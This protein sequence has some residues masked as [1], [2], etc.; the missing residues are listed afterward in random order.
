MQYQLDIYSVLNEII[1][2]DSRELD[3]DCFRE[4]DCERLSEGEQEIFKLLK[5]IASL[6][7]KYKEGE[8]VFSPAIEIYGKGRSFGLQDMT[9]DDYVILE[10]IEVSRLPVLLQAR[11]A[12]ILWTERKDYKIVPVAIK[13]YHE[14]YNI[15][16]DLENWP[17]CLR[18]IKRSITL[19]AKTGAKK[20]YDKY[21]K[22]VFD[23]VIE[24]N[25]EDKYFFSISAIEFLIL[26]KW[27]DCEPLFAVLD[28][29]IEKSEDNVHKVELAYELKSKLFSKKQDNDA[30]MK[31]NLQLALFYEKSADKVR[32]K[33]VQGIFN[34]ERY[35]QKA[36]FLYRNNGSADKGET[37]HRKLLDLQK[38]IPKLMIPIT[39]KRDFTKNYEKIVKLFE[40]LSFEEHVVRIVQCVSFY[41]KESL[42]KKVLEDAVNPIACLFGSGIKNG[43][44]QT[45]IDIPPLDI[46]NPESDINVLEMHMHQNALIMEEMKGGFLLKIA[47]DLLNERFDYTKN[48]LSFIVKGNPIIPE[49]RENIFLS[50][51]YYGL[52]DDIYV[53]LHILAPQ[54][55]KLFRNIAEN[56]GGI[57]YTLENNGSSQEKLL[58]SIFDTPELVECYDNDILF[59]F[60]GLMNEK[61]GA[62]IRNE[63]AHGIMSENK[64][65]GGVARFFL[66]AVLK[67]LSLTSKEYYKILQE[68]DALKRIVDE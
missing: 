41:S 5:K 8:A 27:K 19:A 56:T 43:K 62:N 25:G 30:M 2:P 53:A 55:E 32:D 34:A 42:K 21:R 54:T 49:G 44:G 23:K 36:I 9:E 57:M 59:L 16:F 17:T 4:K 31:N 12:D 6:G 66:C 11:V 7:V 29:I 50:A 20:F 47:I 46:N 14:L 45:L 48:D 35:L 33:D 28:N 38:Q 65:N 61:A 39:A 37:A 60:K 68:S 24:V 64:G 1:T 52:K 22:E 13:A 18:Y 15:T 26:Q 67:L 10:K 58:T 63:I 3:A 51:L 40:H